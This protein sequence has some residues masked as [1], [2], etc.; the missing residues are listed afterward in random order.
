MLGFMGRKVLYHINAKFNNATKFFCP[1]VF[2]RNISISE[3]CDR[4][5]QIMVEYYDELGE[6][7]FNNKVQEM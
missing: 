5:L 6:H 2:V 1:S 7:S 3:T 4:L